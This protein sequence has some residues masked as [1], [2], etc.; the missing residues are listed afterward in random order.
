MVLPNS[1]LS[2]RFATGLH[3]YAR[4]CWGQSGCFWPMYF[5]PMHVT[6][7]EPD[8]GV[9]YTYADY[10]SLRDPSLDKVL[11]LANVTSSI[12]YAAAH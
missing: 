12:A 5:F 9:G 2:I 6:T 3:D 7:L 4:S 8:V 10:V 1:K 11:A